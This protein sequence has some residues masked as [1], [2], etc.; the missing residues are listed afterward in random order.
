MFPSLLLLLLFWVIN[1][2]FAVIIDVVV[3]ALVVII[4]VILVK[5]PSIHVITKRHYEQK[6]EGELPLLAPIFL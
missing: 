1:P 5:D 6:K 4:I 2:V 3:P